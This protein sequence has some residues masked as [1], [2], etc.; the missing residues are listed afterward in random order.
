MKQHKN[1]LNVDFIGGQGSLTKEEE[2][3]ISEYI[4]LEKL[5]R[6]RQTLKSNSSATMLAKSS[7]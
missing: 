1:E 6:K 5:K 3:A 2:T 7:F 4:K